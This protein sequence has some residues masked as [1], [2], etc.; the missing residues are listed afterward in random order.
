M[1]NTIDKNVPIDFSIEEEGRKNVK[2]SAQ[3]G[4]KAYGTGP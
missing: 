4:N 3:L 2:W 1:V